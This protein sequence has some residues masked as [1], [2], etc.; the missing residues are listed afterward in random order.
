MRTRQR[1]LLR[2][3]GVAALAVALAACGGRGGGGDGGG[4]GGTSAD[5]AEFQDA[6]LEYAECMR[7]QGV[8]F[9]DPEPGEDGAV[10]VGPD[11]DEGPPTAAEQEEL[12]AADAECKGILEDVEGSL[13]EPSPEEQREMQDRALAFAECMREAG[14]D[15]PDPEFDEGGR[16]TFGIGGG[17]GEG[18]V[19]PTDPEFQEAQEA[20]TEETGGMGVGA[21]P[22]PG[23][24]QG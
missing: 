21:A 2:T 15:F 8:D 11:P 5:P 22:R 20:C 4:G 6:M 9:P 16:M 1:P 18:G 7:D 10:L 17:V 14:I 24:E 3:T 13:P 12:A 23:N 19:D